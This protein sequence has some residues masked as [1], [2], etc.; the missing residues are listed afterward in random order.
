MSRSKTIL[1]FKP[2]DRVKL[3]GYFLACTGHS[4]GAKIW[5]VKACTC[6]RCNC[7]DL[8]ERWVNTGGHVAAA[9]L[10]HHGKPSLRNEAPV[11]GKVYP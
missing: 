5:T 4:E 2:G 11:I 1:T 10:V 9:N 3:S 7:P 8:A 6:E